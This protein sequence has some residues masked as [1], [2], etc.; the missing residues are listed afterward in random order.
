[1]TISIAPDQF[2]IGV[3]FSAPRVPHWLLV[4]SGTAA[5]VEA[6]TCNAFVRVTRNGSALTPYRNHCH[7]RQ[8]PLPGTRSALPQQ[9]LPELT[10]LF[11]SD[12]SGLQPGD[13]IE[14]GSDPYDTTAYTITAIDISTP[15]LQ[16]C[17][18]TYSPLKPAGRY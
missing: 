13:L 1:M 11:G 17:H 8:W 9:P 2:A 6:Q 18:A 14:T 5:A 10:I 4:V 15:G 12:P 7:V 16:L 3:A